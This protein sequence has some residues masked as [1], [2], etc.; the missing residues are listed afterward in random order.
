[1]TV[2]AKHYAPKVKS[3]TT[4]MPPTPYMK[5]NLNAKP[6][7]RTRGRLDVTADRERVTCGACKARM[8]RA[9]EPALKL[10]DTVR[11]SGSAVRWRVVELCDDGTAN[12]RSLGT[13]KEVNS[14]EL[15]TLI[16][17]NNVGVTKR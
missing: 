9:A 1:M 14:S 13:G 15:G 4:Y 16:L 10:E 3:D 8:P 12:L 7:C 6:L 5:A 2:Y 11:V 17:A